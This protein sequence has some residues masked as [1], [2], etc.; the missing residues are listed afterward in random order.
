MW[1]VVSDTHIT[2]ATAYTLTEYPV[3][4]DL[5]DALYITNPSWLMHVIAQQVPAHHT[6]VGVVF[7][8]PAIRAVRT[9]TGCEQA[10]VPCIDPASHGAYTV[11]VPGPLFFQYHS[12]FFALGME[13]MCMTTHALF[14]A[15]H[16][17]S[18]MQGC[19]AYEAFCRT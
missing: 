9:Y 1:L 3:S 15:S 17:R 4:A 5:C 14:T 13:L 6:Q 7:D 18:I 8:S 19:A 10:L 11:L 12:I 16:T 2:C